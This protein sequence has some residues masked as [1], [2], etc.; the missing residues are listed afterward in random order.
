MR[1]VD[2]GRTRREHAF[3]G[4]SWRALVFSRKGGFLQRAS[5]CLFL[6]LYAC[7]SSPPD[8]ED[9][10]QTEQDIRP[11]VICNGPV[12]TATTDATASFC[13]P[14][15]PCCCVSTI[16]LDL[17]GDA[18]DLTDWRHGVKFELR[19]GRGSIVSW[20]KPGFDDAWL[21]MDR[22]G[23][24][25]IDDGSELFGTFM[26]Q[27]REAGKPRNGFAA[28]A[29]LDQNHVGVVDI[30]DPGFYDLR[31]WQDRNH[32]RLSDPDELLPLLTYGVAGISTTYAEPARS[33]AN[34]NRFQYSVLEKP[35][36]RTRPPTTVR[37]PVPWGA[38]T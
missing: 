21:V 30:R 33:D 15:D 34:G 12:G 9:I 36:T 27:L 16:L 37:A 10:S 24:S 6:V 23:N 18:F 3:G 1:T 31:F 5:A 29:M 38:S 19:P 4:D 14:S 11:A 26:Q 13:S 28:L 35:S 17:A 20:T 8:P 25:R 2:P 22:N 7:T 32:D